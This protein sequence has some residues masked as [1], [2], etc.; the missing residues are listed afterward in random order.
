MYEKRWWWWW[1]CHT[2]ITA[3]HIKNENMNDWLGYLVYVCSVHMLNAKRN[4]TKNKM[5]NKKKEKEEN[6]RELPSFNTHIHVSCDCNKFWCII[7]FSKH[8]FDV[9]IGTWNLE[10]WR[11]K[12]YCMIVIYTKI[13]NQRKARAARRVSQFNTI[14][15]HTPHH[16]LCHFKHI[17]YIIFCML[18]IGH[19][20]FVELPCQCHIVIIKCSSALPQ[21]NESKMIGSDCSNSTLFYW[22]FLPVHCNV[23]KDI[24]IS[25]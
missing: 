15:I 12:I 22:H 16:S 9:L 7:C 23:A 25:L 18:R 4:K 1:H 13:S 21:L 2:S 19:N 11:M 24:L 6:H 3:C 14:P 5:Q 20:V 10:H 17:C 8:K